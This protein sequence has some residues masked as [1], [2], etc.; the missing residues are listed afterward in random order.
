MVTQQGYNRLGIDLL[1]LLT[2]TC[3][4]YWGPCWDDETS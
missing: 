3:R 4:F 1:L 2:G